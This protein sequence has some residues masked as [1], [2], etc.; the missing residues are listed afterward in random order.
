MIDDAWTPAAVVF[1]CDG[2]LMDTETCWTVAETALFAKRGLRFGPDDKARFLGR[3]LASVSGV[4][5]GLF[6]EEGRDDAIGA[7]L[8]ALVTEVI[9]AEAEPMPGAVELVARAAGRVPVGVATNS[10]RALLD[11][12][13]GRGDFGVAFSVSVAIDEVARGKPAPDIYLAACARLG[14]VPARSVGFEDSPTGLAAA[15]AAGMRTVGV[16]GPGPAT[17]DADVVLTSL[18]DPALTSWVDTW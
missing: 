2:L 3:S 9:A 1:D 12:A 15:S 18:T 10:P 13:L 14:Q 8:L 4:M 6:D 11:V 7:E 17:V 16:P 5:A